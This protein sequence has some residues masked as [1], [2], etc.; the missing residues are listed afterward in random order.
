VISEGVAKKQ[1]AQYFYD[2]VINNVIAN[3]TDKKVQKAYLDILVN[4]FETGVFS[5]G[6]A[7]NMNSDDV[8]A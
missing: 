6:N 5:E 7:E 3:S 2:N 4:K 1:N 8:S